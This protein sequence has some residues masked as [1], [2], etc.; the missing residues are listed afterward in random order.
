MFWGMWRDLEGKED[1]EKRGQCDGERKGRGGGEE[2]MIG[3]RGFY[4]CGEQVERAW[5]WQIPRLGPRQRCSTIHRTEWSSRPAGLCW[6]G[7]AVSMPAY[8][9]STTSAEN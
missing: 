4:S 6:K 3:G 2:E 7:W 8:V 1:R 5:Q 9:A